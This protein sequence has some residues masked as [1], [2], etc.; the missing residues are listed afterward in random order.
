L[1]T[2]SWVN[3]SLSA[4]GGAPT[5]IGLHHLH[6]QEMGSRT[7]N[8]ADWLGPSLLGSVAPSLPWVL[9]DFSLS[10][11]QLHHFDDVILTSKIEGLL[12]WSPGFYASIL[13]DFPL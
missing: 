9:W 2:A 6:A 3:G 1:W 12:A 11:L 5:Y 10:P 13:G 8:S 4:N 7:A